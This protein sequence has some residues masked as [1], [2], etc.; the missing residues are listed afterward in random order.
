VKGSAC[1][2]FQSQAQCGEAKKYWERVNER[3]ER[4]VQ[5]LASLTGWSQTSIRE[6]MGKEAPKAKEPRWYQKLWK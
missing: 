4:E 1:F 3:R 5:T 6:R 2:A